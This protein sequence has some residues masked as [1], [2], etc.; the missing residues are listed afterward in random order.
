VGEKKIQEKSGRGLKNQ[1]NKTAEKTGGRRGM[2]VA[3]LTTEEEVYLTSPLPT[4][5]WRR[6]GFLAEEEGYL[7]D[8]KEIWSRH[9]LGGCSRDYG[10]WERHRPHGGGPERIK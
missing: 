9:I 1:F 7:L 2:V 3:L 5:R 8:I 4:G 6:E 10:D